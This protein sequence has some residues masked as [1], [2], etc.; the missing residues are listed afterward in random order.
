M[1]II[2]L[3]TPGTDQGASCCKNILDAYILS[4]ISYFPWAWACC[5]QGEPHACVRNCLSMRISYCQGLFAAAK[6]LT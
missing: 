5:M 6:M 2:D 3:V 1:R 4:K